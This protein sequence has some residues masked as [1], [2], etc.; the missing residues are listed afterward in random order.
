MQLNGNGDGM[1]GAQILVVE[2]QPLVALS[3]ARR[4]Q[5]QGY[6]VI[7]PVAS[8]EEAVKLAAETRPDLILM[9]IQLEG[10]IDGIEAAD[11]I[12]VQLDIPVV[13]ITAVIN[14]KSIQRARITAPYGYLVKPFEEKELKAA[15]EMALYRYQMEQ[16]FKESERRYRQLAELSP[17]AIIVE[18]AGEMVFANPAAHTLLGV[19][20]T[21]ELVGRSFA[22]F[23]HPDH[24]EKTQKIFQLQPGEDGPPGF[25]DQKI[26]SVDGRVVDTELTAVPISYGDGAAVQIVARDVTQRKRTEQNLFQA[27][28]LESLS[29]LAG[30]VAHDF[31]N[32]LVALLGQIGLAAAKLPADSESSGHLGKATEAAQRASELAQQLLVYSGRGAFE[33]QLIDLNAL[34]LENIKLFTAV[35]PAHINI[36][37]QLVSSRPFVDGDVAQLRE[38]IVNLVLNAAEA[39]GKQPGV[40]TIRTSTME[41]GADDDHLWR[42]TG[43]PLSPGLYHTL[44]VLDSGPALDEETKSRLLDP[45]FMTRPAE[46]GLGLATVL[47]IVRGYG[48]GLE[49]TSE[50]GQGTSFKLLFAGNKEA[51]PRAPM[52]APDVSLQSITGTL[53]V[54]DDEMAVREAVVDILESEAIQVIT[55]E[56]GR[57]GLE[58]Y[59]ANLAE[60]DL[61]LLDLSMPEMNGDETFRELRRINPKVRVVLSSGYDKLNVIQQFDNRGLQEFLQKPYDMATLIEVVKRNMR[62]VVK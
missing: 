35:I 59:Q 30:G 11:Q 26:V 2:D 50:P 36:S 17:D 1:N 31:N 14:E 15:I 9:D 38:A 53:L 40:I 22:E 52:T 46:H 58:K 19:T 20:D 7:G 54:I 18:K 51:A 8:G 5:K 41:V 55:A 61:V 21:A 43:I 37:S 13:F 28:K 25:L 39:I 57:E 42:Y 12:R 23:V 27:R 24:Q 3:M 16:R 49:I 47:G 10:P 32:L 33:L 44:E 34:V 6:G 56:S 60:I 45:F 62:V 48:G 29:A 4:L